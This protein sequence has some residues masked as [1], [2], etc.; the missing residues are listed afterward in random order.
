MQPL[1]DGERLAPD[2]AVRM[3]DDARVGVAVLARLMKQRQ[4]IRRVR[5]DVRQQDVVEAPAR[6]ELLAGRDLE[7]ELQMLPPRELDHAGAEV[8]A[9][10]FRRFHRG[11]HVACTAADLEHVR[12]G[13]TWKRMICS[14]RRW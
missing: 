11:E 6:V 12:P 4:E 7:G 9:H 10:A 1:R 2:A 14:T 13:G 3:N 5:N 8:D